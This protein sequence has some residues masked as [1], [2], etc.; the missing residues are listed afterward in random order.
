MTNN[1]FHKLDE[2][3]KNKIL[4]TAL[5]EFASNGFDGSSI[6]RISKM[7]GLSAGNLYYYFENKEDL[8]L[9]VVDYVFN[10]FKKS[11]DRAEFSF[12]DEVEQLVRNRVA[13]SRENKVVSRFLNRF[14]EY[15]DN[16]NG[17]GVERITIEKVQNEF[18]IIF[19]KGIECGEIRND[20]DSEYLFNLHLG[21]VLTTNRWILKNIDQW[22][23][24]T[25]EKF[26]TESIGFI[27]SA[28]QPSGRV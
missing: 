7:A 18:R 2:E 25:A 9:T 28:M 11:D 5:E 8:Y 19:D 14:F 10:T 23:D 3:K 22:D 12:W 27:K 1:R 21:L 6:N 17:S 16:H 26:I 20:L 4:G 13:I 24:E 15:A